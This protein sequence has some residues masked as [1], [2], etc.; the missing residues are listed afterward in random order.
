[1][2]R[3]AF[4]P[5]AAALAVAVLTA[6][7]AYAN[8]HEVQTNI[9]HYD[10]LNLATAEGLNELDRRLDGAVA[11]VCSKSDTNGYSELDHYKAWHHCL[12]G[13][14]ASARQERT[15][16]LAALDHDQ[17]NPIRITRK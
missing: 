13:A 2:S 11:Y 7:P 3:I 12:R 8:N 15:T 1:M 4:T 10:D 6:S 16:V 5:L 9:V 14:R 17:R